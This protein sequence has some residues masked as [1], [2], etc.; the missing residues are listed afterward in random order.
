MATY[1]KDMSSDDL[2]VMIEDVVRATLENYI[3]DLQALASPAYLD[4]IAEAREDYRQGK[5][6][7]LEDLLDG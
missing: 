7:S 2:R 6:V 3:E 5:T 1:V 4:S